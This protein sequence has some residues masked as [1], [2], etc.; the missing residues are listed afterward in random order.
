MTTTTLPGLSVALPTIPKGHGRY[1]YRC[2]GSPMSAHR[3][4]GT[5][6]IAPCA[7]VWLTLPEE[8]IR[9]SLGYGRYQTEIRPVSPPVRCSCG[10]WLSSPMRLEVHDSGQTKITHTCENT[11][12]WSESKTC[13]CACGGTQH[14]VMLRAPWL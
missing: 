9:R 6:H 10:S 11:C 7:P 8:R 1:M 4:D 2:S 14:G 5:H 13:R 3:Y 12:Q